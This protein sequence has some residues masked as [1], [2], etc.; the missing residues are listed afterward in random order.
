MAS[1]T[2]A[3]LDE[4]MEPVELRND[5]LLLRLPAEHDVDAVSKACQDPEIQRWIPVPVPYEREHAA[6][7]VAGASACW[8]ADGELRWALTDAGTDAF[9]GA[10]SLHAHSDAAVREIGFWT[11]PWARG[12][13]RT[14][15]A[16]RLVCR[17]AFDA[18]P[19]AR[20]FWL[21]AVGNEGSR[22]V[23]DRAGFTQ[24]GTLRHGI[25]HR[26]ER[27][28]AWIASLLPADM[29]RGEIG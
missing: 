4:P 26:G 28:D 19:V 29:P 23:A 16:V 24:E 10:M 22:K 6:D 27:R 15:D 20:I 1:I 11:A 7:W 5:R 8:A 17:W 9:L 14:T 21:A 2:L 12:S 13:G 18:L 3:R 25:G